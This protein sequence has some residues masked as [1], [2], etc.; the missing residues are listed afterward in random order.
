MQ[1]RLLQ[2]Q[3]RQLKVTGLTVTP[4]STSQLNIVWNK[5]PES[6]VTHYNVYRGTSSGFSV[7]PG[8]TPAIGTF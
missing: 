6:D 7:T 1:R 3:H 4:V 2:I 8:V 5:N